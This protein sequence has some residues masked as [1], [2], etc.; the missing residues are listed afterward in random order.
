AKGTQKNQLV[1]GN[2][3]SLQKNQL[4]NNYPKQEE[5]KEIE[6]KREECLHKSKRRSV[7]LA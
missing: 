3:L 6:C 4:Q 1:V 2:L 5:D 7:N